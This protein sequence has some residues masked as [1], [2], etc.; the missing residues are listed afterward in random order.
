LPIGV[1]KN[2]AKSADFLTVKSH[3]KE[4]GAAACPLDHPTPFDEGSMRGIDAIN[5]YN[6]TFPQAGRGR[7]VD[8]ASAISPAAF[9]G[10]FT[11]RLR[12]DR[13]ASRSMGSGTPNDNTAEIVWSPK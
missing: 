3:I 9:G 11:H 1:G 4:M 13:P 12:H 8:G 6:V 7:R 10:S 2:E 5:V